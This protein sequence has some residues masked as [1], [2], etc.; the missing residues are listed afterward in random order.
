[1]HDS[2]LGRSVLANSTC[3]NHRVCD[4]GALASIY[5]VLCWTSVVGPRRQFYDAPVYGHKISKLLSVGYCGVIH[6]HCCM[7]P[8]GMRQRG[9]DSDP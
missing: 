9:M 2:P 6:P 4:S 8:A 7:P 1:M 3:R 5:F